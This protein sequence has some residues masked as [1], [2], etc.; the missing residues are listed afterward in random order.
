MRLRLVVC[1]MISALLAGIIAWPGDPAL[2]QAQNDPNLVDLVSLDS[3]LGYLTDL[4]SIQ[5]YSGWRN[6]ASSGEQEAV[7]YVAKTVGDMDFLTGLG[8]TTEQQE[9]HVYSSTEIWTSELVV[10]VSGEAISVPAD[11]QRGPRWALER[12]IR[13]DS[14]GTFNDAESD[15]VVVSGEVVLVPD[16]D[17]VYNL[18]G[19]DMSGKILIVNYAAVDRSIMSTDSAA[20]NAW[21]LVDTNPAGIL[22]LTQFSNTAGE[23]HGA[24]VGDV[25]AFDWVESEFNPPVL[26]ARIEDM[27]PAGDMTWKDLALIESAE[28]TWDVD[29]FS[30]GT[31]RNLIVRIPGADSSRNVILGAH[32]DS[33]NSPGALDDGS[34]SVVLLEVARVLNESQTQPPVDVYLVWF[35]SEEL[36][37]YGSAHFVVTHQELLDNS[38]AHLNV[39]C[40]THPLDGL[41]VALGLETWS[42]ARMGDDSLHWSDYL[43]AEAEALGIEV[44]VEDTFLPVSDSSSFAGFGIP[45]ANLI[46]SDDTVFYTIGGSVHYGG[47]LHDPYDTVALVEPYG[48]VLVDMAQIAVI[49]AT[50]TGADQPT[51][52]VMQDD[53]V[54]RAVFVGTHT[55]ATTL[56]PIV[57]TEIGLALIAA[58][59]DVDMIPFGQTITAD[60]LADAKIVFALPPHDY[61]EAANGEDQYDVA[62]SDD[63]IALIT[64][65]VNKG[66]VLV[67]I[68][69]ANALDFAG[70][71]AGVNEDWADLNALGAPFGI[72]YVEDVITS[73]YANIDS[74]MALMEGITSV[75][76]LKENGVPFE[77]AQGE[78]LAS[79][80]GQPVIAMVEHGEGAVI[81]MADWGFFTTEYGESPRNLRFWKNLGAFAA[82][83]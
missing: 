76:L 69:S 4:T 57:S 34:G 60:D 64:E 77:I 45:H 74:G 16:A 72:T 81:A 55:E 8:L 21:T 73:K 66:G 49:A 2:I 48:D 25:S 62:W 7:D 68:N 40:L 52:R 42:F 71:Q 78:V 15:L 41:K 59:L 26:Y 58:G 38:L 51:L 12:A 80:N 20:E 37:L 33:P 36:G 28:L 5:P 30:P 11:A 44:H 13:F 19:A 24:F 50:Q 27:A 17:T 14:D 67:L 35:G 82:G 9:F 23:S 65:Y 3:M 39:D 61:P 56:S 63:E 22:L 18:R 53:P 47:H 70:R 83:R 1:F 10:T 32:I 6:S 79:V 46:Y 43:A 54:G 75:V 31:S 29:V